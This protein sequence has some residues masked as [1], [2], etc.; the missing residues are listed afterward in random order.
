M[1]AAVIRRIHGRVCQLRSVR[2]CSTAL[3]SS[4]TGV[5][6]D[7]AIDRI[8]ID[9]KKTSGDSTGCRKKAIFVL[10]KSPQ[11]TLVTLD[12]S[13]LDGFSRKKRPRRLI[14]TSTCFVLQA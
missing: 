6:L 3:F 11:S 7:R 13:Q 14:A 8:H 1:D 5:D 10:F 9:Y 2:F 4:G 12:A